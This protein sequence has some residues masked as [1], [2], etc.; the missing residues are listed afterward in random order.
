MRTAAIISSVLTAVLVGCEKAPSGASSSEGGATT[1]T[2]DRVVKPAENKDNGHSHDH[3][4]SES[5]HG[6]GIEL[7]SIKIGA[8]D[9]K[10]S[11]DKGEIKPGGEAA[12]DVWINGGRGEGVTA[13]RFWI[14]TQDAGG[15]VKAKA[16]IEG[17]HW[18]THVEVPNPIPADAK[19]WIEIE[20]EKGGKV[21][22]A[23]E[24]KK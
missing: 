23:V 21:S 7:G 8:Y 16:E 19:A 6:E 9:V 4:K 3:G 11:R 22:G 14:G 20:S 2:G 10:V 17:S 12:I 1:A 13:V 5:H 15:S 18:H 24:L